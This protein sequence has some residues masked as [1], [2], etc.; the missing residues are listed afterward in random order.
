MKKLI[1]LLLVICIFCPLLAGCGN[2]DEDFKMKNDWNQEINEEK[3]R[4]S[5][6]APPKIKIILTLNIQHVINILAPILTRSH[7]FVKQSLD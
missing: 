2:R 3:R 4:F 5:E 6:Q 1:S 7:S